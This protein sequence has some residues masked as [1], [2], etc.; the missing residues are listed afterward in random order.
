MKKIIILLLAPFLF[1]SCVSMYGT[2]YE[3]SSK[4]ART[5]SLELC[6]KIV[7]ATLA[8]EIVRE[9]WAMEL[10]RRSEN[11]SQY[12]AA[13]NAAVQN[14]ANLNALS[15]SL[16]ESSRPYTLGNS[17][18]NSS[19]EVFGSAYLQNNYVS[20]MNRICV[21]NNMGSTYTKTVKASQLCPMSLN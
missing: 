5:S 4:N 21:Y 13:I 1:N 15:Q 3:R 18:T 16:L 12:S 14:Q 10:Q 2:D 9:E 6:K 17:N 8:P 11:C 7:I 20:G 19:S